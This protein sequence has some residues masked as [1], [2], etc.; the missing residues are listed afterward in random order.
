MKVAKGAP[1]DQAITSDVTVTL[2]ASAQI[3]TVAITNDADASVAD[4][5]RTQIVKGSEKFDIKA[6]IQELVDS[7]KINAEQYILLSKGDLGPDKIGDATDGGKF[8]KLKTTGDGFDTSTKDDTADKLFIKAQDILDLAA[9]ELPIEVGADTTITTVHIGYWKLTINATEFTVSGAE[10][11]V[12]GG[13]GVDIVAKSSASIYVVDN[14]YVTITTLPAD[15][16]TV[17][18][19]PVDKTSGYS[20]RVVGNEEWA[21]VYIPQA[22]LAGDAE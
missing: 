5:T 10:Y 18:N 2:A 16:A 9:A 12:N 3:Q 8:W 11:S 17:N 21:L 15:D 14:C 1:A 19:T 22:P 7:K 4:T 13:A 20:R 6:L